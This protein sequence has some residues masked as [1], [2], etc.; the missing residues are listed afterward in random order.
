MDVIAE[1]LLTVYL[2]LWE[3]GEVPAGW[4][5]ASIIPSFKKNVGE[6]PENYRPVSPTSV[7]G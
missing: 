1:P 3:S 7:S 5:V 4:K 2:K 6:D